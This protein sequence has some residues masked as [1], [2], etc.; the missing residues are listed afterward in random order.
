MSDYARASPDDAT[1]RLPILIHDRA[2]TASL[3]TLCACT[4]LTA[5]GQAQ[6]PPVQTE[7]DRPVMEEIVVTGT[8]IARRDYE[9]AS[10]IVTVDSSLFDQSGS[11]TVQTMLNTLPQFAPWH[12][13]NTN[14]RPGD[15][16]PGAGQAIMDLRG[17]GM[18]RTLVLLDGRR[19]VPSNAWGSVDVNLI[20][21]AIIDRV[22]IISGGASAVYGSDAVAGV[23]NF[24]TRRF[25]GLETEASWEQT[26]RHDGTGWQA[27][28]TGGL[29]F[30]RGYAYGHYSYTERDPVMQGDRAFSTF[31]LGYDS[32]SQEFYPDGSGTIRQGRWIQ[33]FD[34]L[35]TQEAIDAY[36]SRV[37]STYVPGTVTAHTSFGFNPDG[38][39]F[40]Q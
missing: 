4:L 24:K 36:L 35:P 32:E 17:L 21:A 12:T 20:P 38:S 30:A 10:P 28:M 22:E 27:G 5:P 39:L 23:V 3:T 33:R 29:E 14:I 26:D 19:I 18:G 11:T 9:S 8:R 15:T 34:N 6:E 25:T 7:P 37:D 31:A 16:D 1:H 13:E 40:S 2:H